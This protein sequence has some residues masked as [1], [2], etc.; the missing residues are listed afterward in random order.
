MSFYNVVV[1]FG[2]DDND[3]EDDNNNSN[4]INQAATNNLISAGRV[5]DSWGNP[6][7]KFN[8]LTKM[9]IPQLSWT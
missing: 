9:V 7:P 1:W 8:I 5:T 2:D 3:D 4:H 6:L